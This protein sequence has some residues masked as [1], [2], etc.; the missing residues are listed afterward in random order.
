MST[1]ATDNRWSPSSSGATVPEDAPAAYSARWIDQGD[2]IPAD[3]L[4]DRQGFAYNHTDDRDVLISCLTAAGEAIRIP[5]SVRDETSVEVRDGWRIATRRA[6]GYIY[7]DAWLV[8]SG[9]GTPRVETVMCGN[10]LHGEDFI[11]YVVRDDDECYSIHLTNEE[12]KAALAAYEAHN[13][14][15]TP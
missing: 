8:P 6:G 14:T 9:N 15:V 7:V 13:G 4:P 10:D 1:Y 2:M 3:V 12:A 5:P 11:A